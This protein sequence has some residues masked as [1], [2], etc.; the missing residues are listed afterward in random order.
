MPAQDV[1][2]LPWFKQRR[3][4]EHVRHSG[5]LG[6]DVHG[7]GATQRAIVESHDLDHRPSLADSAR[8]A[9]WR[10]GRSRR[11][12]A[13]LHDLADARRSEDVRMGNGDPC[14]GF[15]AR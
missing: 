7:N 2:N 12:P 10:T 11:R 14:V 13:R 15:R 8:R 5:V 3:T 9:L 4:V 1:S 6:A